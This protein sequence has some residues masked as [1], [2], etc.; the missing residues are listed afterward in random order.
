MAKFPIR[1]PVIIVQQPKEEIEPEIVEVADGG[2]SVGISI[3]SMFW[4]AVL[5]LLLGLGVQ[6]A[7]SL[8][9]SVTELLYSQYFYYY[10]VRWMSVITKFFSFSLGEVLVVLVLLWFGLWIPWYLFRAIKRQTRFIDVIKV[11]ILHVAWLLSAGFAV[12]LIMWGLNFQ[13]IPLDEKLN[14]DSRP[15]GAAELTEAGRRIVD[16][17]NRNYFF[18]R[19]G[20]EAR[21]DNTMTISRPK[22]YQLIENAFQN[23]TLLGDASQGGFGPPKALKI[24]PLLSWFGLNGLYNPY[25]G[26][27]TYNS[28]IPDIELPFA[29]AHGKAHQR[30]YAREEEANFIA[31]IVCIKTNDPYVRYSGFVHAAKVLDALAE[32]DR[33][34]ADD[35][36]GQI[37]PEPFAEMRAREEFWQQAKSPRLEP[38]ADS[39]LDLYLRSNRVRGGLK[40]L[41]EDTPLIVSYLLRNPD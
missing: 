35:L 22:M 36:R 29:I 34:M 39:V 14:L 27:V 20:P 38:L 11:L 1:P 31:F 17:I 6:T 13:R 2:E 26:E 30:G 33:P 4:R 3:R 25:S 15:S 41:K 21:A 7:A 40:N 32:T 5:W 16:G 37:A 23:E 28:N 24:S 8:M 9:P 12:F 18:A 19:E 10:L